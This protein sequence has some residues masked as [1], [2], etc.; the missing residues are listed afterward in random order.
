MTKGYEVIVAGKVIWTCKDKDEAEAKL[1]EAKASFLR[2]V[3][4]VDVFYIK[5]K[6]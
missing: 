1:A 6:E 2:M 3:H 5:E 4:P